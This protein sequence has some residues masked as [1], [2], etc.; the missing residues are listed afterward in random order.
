MIEIKDTV[1]TANTAINR[2]LLLLG[3]VINFEQ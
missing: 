3:V 2:P 1:Q